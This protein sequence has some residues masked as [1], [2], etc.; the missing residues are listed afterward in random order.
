VHRLLWQLT[1]ALV[2]A[3]VPEA[4]I[5]VISPYRSQ[6]ALLA[7]RLSPWRDVEVRSFVGWICRSIVP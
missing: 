7:D 3:G 1:A 2:H 5:G 6:L 4:A